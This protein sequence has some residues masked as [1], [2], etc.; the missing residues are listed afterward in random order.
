M[1]NTNVRLVLLAGMATTAG[2]VGAQTLDQ[3][4]GY[5]AELLA[6][7]EQ[8]TSLLGA[9][10]SNWSS[11]QAEIA[12]PDGTFSLGVSAYNQ[13]R[14]GFLLGDDN[15]GTSD[16]FETG[17]T[18]PRTRIILDGNVVNPDTYYRLE[19][20][21][22]E[23][24]SSVGSGTGT[25]LDYYVGHRFASGL[26]LEAGQRKI[27]HMRS[28][29]QASNREQL[30]EGT[31][32]EGVFNLG[33]SQGLFGSYGNEQDTWRFSGA[34]TDGASTA[35]TPVT[36]ANDGD[37]AGTGRF[38]YAFQGTVSAYDDSVRQL[39]GGDTGAIAGGY[40]HIQQNPN[41]PAVPQMTIVQWGVDFLYDSPEGWNI[42]AQFGH[43][44][45]DTTGAQTLNDFF[46]TVQGGFFINDQTEIV[47]AWDCISPDEDRGGT[48]DPFNTLQANVNYF[49]FVGTQAI[50]LAAGVAI[51]IDD[52]ADTGGLV[53]ENLWV[54]LRDGA[55]DGQVAVFGSVQSEI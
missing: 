41:Q 43:R 28:F 14:F 22:D 42:L 44:Y 25:L 40:F 26:R 30:I 29:N 38:D 23:S 51:F 13:T 35:N 18:L 49:P 33:R 17:F 31:V 2:A 34:F 15:G 46:L 21:F 12:N 10:T 54:G 3:T 48:D 6:D 9:P 27:D 36:A 55:G 4:R 19:F 37:W 1:R 47:G 20:A 8:R 45:T 7:A 16:D 11:G 5:A 24:S 32:A 50:K 52:P 39:P 53:T